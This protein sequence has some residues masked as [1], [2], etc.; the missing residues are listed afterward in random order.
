MHGVGKLDGE[1]ERKGLATWA[2]ACTKIK[3][4]RQR[5]DMLYPKTGIRGGFFLSYKQNPT[6]FAI[7]P[8]LYTPIAA[9]PHLVV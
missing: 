5:Y 4:G 7:Y 8:P 6:P 3:F 1:G 2:K 9:L